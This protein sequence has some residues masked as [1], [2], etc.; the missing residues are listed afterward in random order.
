MVLVLWG[1]G[2]PALCTLPYIAIT[3]A[4][5][6]TCLHNVHYCYTVYVSLHFRWNL[7][8]SSAINEECNHHSHVL[9]SYCHMEHYFH[10]L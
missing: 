2:L 9:H 4:I 1:G 5:Y 6:F 7:G 3:M 10:L 8:K